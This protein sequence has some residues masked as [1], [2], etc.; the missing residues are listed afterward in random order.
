MTDLLTRLE[1]ARLRLR[2]F[3]AEDLEP[4]AGAGRTA[5]PRGLAWSRSG[6]GPGAAVLG[7]GVRRRAARAALDEAFGRLGW[8]R[9]ISLIDPANTRS[10][11]L[12]ERLG[13][14]LD[15]ERVVYSRRVKV[16][17]LLS[18]AWRAAPP[19]SVASPGRPEVD[20]E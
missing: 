3:R 14:R 11:R 12:A 13:E 10:I 17:A 9:V 5:L 20:E 19:S 8:P 15:G 1:T 2:L 6:L 4:H 7:E 16:Y 18:S